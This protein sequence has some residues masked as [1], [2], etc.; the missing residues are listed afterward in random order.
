MRLFASRTPASVTVAD[1]AE[2]AGMTSAAVY[3]HYPS[4]DE[5]LLEGVRAFG[6]DLLARARS[7]QQQVADGHDIGSLPIA[8]VSWLDGRR[9]E[10]AVYFVN[11]RGATLHVESMRRAHRIELTKVFARAAR[12]TGGDIRAAEAG[13]VAAGLVSLFEAAAASW[14]TQDDAYRQLGPDRFLT[15]TGELARRL[16]GR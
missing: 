16:A 15:C 11:S 4:K 5:I 3:Y 6:H 7:C 8:L 12:S 14:V 1:I 10:A 2:E 9:A 13:V